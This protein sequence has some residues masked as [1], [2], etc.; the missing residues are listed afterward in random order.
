[1]L[2][3]TYRYINEELWVVVGPH[4]GSPDHP[5]SP[6]PLSSHVNP[7]KNLQRQY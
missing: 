7:P 3:C 4:R 6:L 1:M 2:L 5:M